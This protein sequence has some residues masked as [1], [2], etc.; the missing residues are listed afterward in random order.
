MCALETLYINFRIST[1]RNFLI[2]HN[3]RN[4]SRLFLRSIHKF[5]HLCLSRSIAMQISSAMFVEPE[6]WVQT[7]LTLR[8]VGSPKDEF[9]LHKRELRRNRKP[10]SKEIQTI[11]IISINCWRIHLFFHVR[12]YVSVLRC[13]YAR[14]IE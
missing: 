8:E 10:S 9:N 3:S 1:V 4:A 7:K 2:A 5:R 14:V 12:F 11:K 13:A 6:L